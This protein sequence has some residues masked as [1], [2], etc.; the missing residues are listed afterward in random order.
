[1]RPTHGGK[2]FELARYQNIPLESVVDFSAN[3]NPLGPPSGWREFL[4]GHLDSLMHYPDSS[5]YDFRTAVAKRFDLDP[6][7][8][9]PGNG[10]SDI[11]WLY[12]RTIRPKKVV[13]ISPTFG[14]YESAFH[15]W[16]RE[17]VHVVTNPLTNFQPDCSA[18]E[19]ALEKAD[20]LIICNPNNPTGTLINPE[21]IDQL[22]ALT[23]ERRV[24]FLI[25][26]SFIEFTEMG[27]SVL[28][29]PIADHL[30][31]L[32]SQTKIGGVPG[33]RL[34]FAVCSD[35][36]LI[37]KMKAHGDSWSMNSLAAAFGTFLENQHEYLE[38]SHVETNR[39]RLK[40]I[41]SLYATGVLAPFPSSA[42][43]VL[44]RILGSITANQLCKRA[45]DQGILI[46]NAESFIGLNNRFVR[47]AVRP[48]HEQERL[49]SF[50]RNL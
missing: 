9:I 35:L 46:R 16:C 18:V 11:L 23:A 28:N 6:S 36:K 3:I 4:N 19:S 20:L 39:L 24:R 8:V 5:Y 31:V 44:C 34:G 12:A 43:F 38:S 42:N 22:I 13:I 40:L 37:E 1:M 25:D 41:E 32:R 49:I 17:I 15:P 29:H 7:H 10:A 45:M 30:F 48:E 21:I 33:L 26:E 27:T 47:I 14:E 2:V 50:L